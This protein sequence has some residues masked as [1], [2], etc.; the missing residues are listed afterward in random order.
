MRSTSP[1]VQKFGTSLAGESRHSRH[2]PK[3]KLGE[4]VL[5]DSGCNV[6]QR[7][8]QSEQHTLRNC[9]GGYRVVATPSN[10]FELDHH[11]S[12]N[13][14]TGWCDLGAFGACGGHGSAR[15]A[16]ARKRRQRN[17]S[18][19]RCHFPPRRAKIEVGWLVCTTI[20]LAPL[21]A[22]QRPAHRR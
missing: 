11:Q 13:Q 20:S 5:A 12:L 3:H 2:R 7:V 17:N 8:A 14:H 15:E 22:T 9:D 1:E 16:G 4:K 6:E 19:I 21:S 18:S 10:S